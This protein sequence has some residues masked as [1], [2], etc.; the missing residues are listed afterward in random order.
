MFHKEAV[1]AAMK[2]RYRPASIGG[3]NVQSQTRIIMK[4]NLK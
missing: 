2:W 4:F 1:D 3:S